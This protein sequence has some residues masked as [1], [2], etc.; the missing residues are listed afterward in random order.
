MSLP[1]SGTDVVLYVSTNAVGYQRNVTFEETTEEIDVSSKEERSKRVLAGRYSSAV[2]LDA[3][4]VPSDTAYGALKTAMRS[5]STV[6]VARYKDGAE[7]EHAD[8]IVTSLSES[9]PDQDGA[10]VSVS[11]VIDG[12]WAT[13]V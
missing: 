12:D 1:I 10:T 4:F 7:I 6:T 13:P 5:G 11:L 2:T 9:F 8:A 3:L